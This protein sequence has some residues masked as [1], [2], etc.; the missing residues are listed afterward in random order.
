MNILLVNPNRYRHPP[1]PPVGLEYIAGDLAAAGH[2]PEILDL[3]FSEG[4]YDDLDR[5]I[6]SFAPEVVGISVRNIDTVLYPANE[7]FLDDIKSLVEHIRKKYCLKVVIGGAGVSAD[8]QGVLEYLGADCAVAGLGE[9]VGIEVLT[10]VTT[11]AFSNGVYERKHTHEISCPRLTAGIDYARYAADGGIAGFETHKGCSSSCIYCIEA[12]TCVSFRKIPEVIRDIQGFAAQGIR[13]FHLCD[14]EFNE[15]LDYS[16]DFLK[17]LKESGV[18]IDWA[19]YLKPSNYNR[20]IFQLMKQT[21]VSLITLTVD[22]WKKCPLY[23]T[24]IEKII[25]SARSNDIKLVVDFLTGFPYEQE[26]TLLFYLDF[27]R[28]LQ[29]DS[30]GINTC[31]RLYRGL[32]VY[33]IISRDSELARHIIYSTHGESGDRMLHPAFFINISQERLRELINGD[34]LFRIEGITK[35]VNYSR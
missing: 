20:K 8:P 32:K 15:D 18:G 23:W 9:G 6:Q 3:C 12:D 1:V 16:L 13:R 34:P 21:G 31:L 4:P 27:F 19:L 29:P 30:V 10:G 25:F 7:F 14:P 22:S 2:S 11:A 35:G 17:A 26:D 28:R 5:A 24:D 33:D